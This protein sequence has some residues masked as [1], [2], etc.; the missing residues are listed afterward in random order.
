MGVADRRLTTACPWMMLDVSAKLRIDHPAYSRYFA[1]TFSY[2]FSL[3]N[4]IRSH[5]GLPLL[6]REELESVGGRSGAA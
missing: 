2:V 6:T 3:W 5:Y 4:R 1:A